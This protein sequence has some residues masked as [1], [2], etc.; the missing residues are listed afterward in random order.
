MDRSLFAER[1]TRFA[2]RQHPGDLVPTQSGLFFN[3]S[4]SFCRATHRVERLIS[5][6]SSTFSSS[7]GRSG[8]SLTTRRMSSSIA[9]HLGTRFRVVSGAVLPDSRR[10]CL[11]RLT[12]DSLT[13][14]RWATSLVPSPES[15]A[16]KTSRRNSFE[17]ASIATSVNTDTTTLPK[18]PP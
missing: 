17:Y 18:L 16:R 5:V 12:H 7:R 4:F 13:R 14:N 3:V 11:I 10:S 1:T 9:R 15:H 2:D 6:P 8:F